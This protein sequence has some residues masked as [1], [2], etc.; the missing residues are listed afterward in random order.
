MK[1]SFF[2]IISWLTAFD[3]LA[4]SKQVQIDLYKRS[5]TQAVALKD[6]Q[7]ALNK[8]DALKKLSHSPF[9]SFHTGSCL[10]SQNKLS[11][12]KRYFQEYFS[13]AENTH[14]YYM[15]AL[16]AYLKIEESQAKKQ[17]GLSIWHEPTTAMSFVK[18][19]KGCYSLRSAS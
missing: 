4:I 8:L 18:I 7:L 6:C 3:C 12:A 9:A 11:E 5:I 15:Q 19:P 17:V 2:F 16:D 13:A 10:L 14:E 1:F